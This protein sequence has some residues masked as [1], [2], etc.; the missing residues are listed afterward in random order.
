MFHAARVWTSRA[1]DDPIFTNPALIF[2]IRCFLVSP[3]MHLEHNSS[4]DSKYIQPFLPPVDTAGQFTELL[5][6]FNDL[7]KDVQGRPNEV[8][9]IPQRPVIPLQD[10]IMSRLN[11]YTQDYCKS[12][13]DWIC[14]Y[15]VDLPLIGN[16][17]AL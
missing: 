11:C 4:S 3:A 10:L 12:L 17:L 7:V 5:Q 15:A 13:V 1:M 16:W 8:G 9:M 6:V 14:Q 2:I